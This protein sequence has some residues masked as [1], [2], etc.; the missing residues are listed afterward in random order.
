MQGHDYT[1]MVDNLER[2][3]EK[4][5]DTYQGVGWKKQED[6]DLQFKVMLEG[7]RDNISPSL[8][9]LDFGCGLAHLYEYILSK[10]IPN[11]EYSGL[12]LSEKF[13]TVCRK[14]FPQ[15]IFFNLDILKHSEALPEHDF[16][17]MNGLFN[18]K[19]EGSHE[20][21]WEYCQALLSQSLVLR[22]AW[23]CLQCNVEA[24]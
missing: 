6:V 11:I 23:H 16:V 14:K 24:S 21:M 5:G 7:I 4:Y 3:F 12:D 13:I 9:L 10:N 8:R 17:I 22:A 20:A 1:R 2:S 18:Y 15:N 19:G